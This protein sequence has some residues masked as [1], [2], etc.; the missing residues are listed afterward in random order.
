MVAQAQYLQNNFKATIDGIN[1]AIKSAKSQ[2]KPLKEDWL[3]LLMSAQNKLGDDAG[4]QAALAQLIAVNPTEAYWKNLMQ[5]ADRATRNAPN[6]TKTALDLYFIKLQV[7][8]LADRQ[9]ILGHGAAR[10]AGRSAGFGQDR[11]GQGLQGRRAR[12]GRDQGPRSPPPDHGVTTQAASDEK[13]LAQ[14]ETEA[15]KAKT[16]DALV[17]A[18]EAYWSYGQYD[19]AAE[20][21]QEGITKGVTSTDDAKLRLGI[22]YISRP[23]RSRRP[24]TPSRASPRAP[25]RRRSRRCGC[26]RPP[27]RRRRPNF[28]LW[29]LQPDARLQ[30]PP[31]FCFSG[32]GAAGGPS[33]PL[34]QL[35]E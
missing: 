26:W 29:R 30:T 14:G 5:Y 11:R 35:G 1:G 2:G 21:I 9:G 16:G 31:A 24:R 22:V 17:K 28:G 13:A 27:A 6:A 20:I 10:A 3:Q 25:Y 18:G 19:K 4:T 33:K 23:A 15:R 32:R 12:F 34:R 8:T 7:G